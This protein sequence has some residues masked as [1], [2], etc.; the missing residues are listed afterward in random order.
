MGRQSTPSK[1]NPLKKM[2]KVITVHPS[3]F[4]DFQETHFAIGTARYHK[5]WYEIRYY[6]ELEDL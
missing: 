5:D 6:E 3:T 1:L 4:V 2:K